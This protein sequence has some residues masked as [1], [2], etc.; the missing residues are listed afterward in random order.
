MPIHH[1]VALGR[2]GHTS[3]AYAEMICSRSQQILMVHSLLKCDTSLASDVAGMLHVMQHQIDILIHAGGVLADATLPNQSL[4]KCRSVFAPKQ[5]ALEALSR[6]TDSVR[7]DSS[8]LFSSVASALG[9]AGQS[10]YG[11]ANAY[12]DVF[13]SKQ[14]STGSTFSSICWGAWFVFFVFVC[15]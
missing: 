2:S 7:M 3:A 13:A 11:A 12:L 5:H 10:N 9:S 1:T 6:V 4:Q 8:I 14:M 15:T